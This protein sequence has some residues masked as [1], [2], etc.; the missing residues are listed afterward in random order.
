MM[1]RGSGITKN[2]LVRGANPMAA[3]QAAAL[4]QA[5][6]DPARFAGVPCMSGG[7]KRG[8][9]INSA[10]IFKNLRRVSE[11]GDA[12]AA[13]SALDP[14]VPYGAGRPGWAVS[15]PDTP[16]N[17][18]VVHEAPAHTLG[19]VIRCLMRHARVRAVA[20]VLAQRPNSIPLDLLLQ[21]L[22]ATSQTSG[23]VSGD[24]VVELVAAMGAAAELEGDAQRCRRFLTRQL[25]FVLL[26]FAEEAT[27]ALSDV[28]AQPLDEL[29]RLGRAASVA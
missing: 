8:G 11:A 19:M 7:A 25:T 28:A 4:A 29:T 18:R 12:N 1:P 13:E 22:M 6:F 9:G 14:Y 2:Q 21:A 24:D 20:A 27:K 3:A 16:P 26:E 23:P 10:A 15:P 5:G 17:W